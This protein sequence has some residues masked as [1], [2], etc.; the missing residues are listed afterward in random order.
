[1]NQNLYI[2]ML[3]LNKTEQKYFEVS[4]I[5]A[6]NLRLECKQFLRIKPQI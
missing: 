2:F 3:K 4:V 6:R 1:M 5:F